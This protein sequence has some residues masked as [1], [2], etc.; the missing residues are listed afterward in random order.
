MDMICAQGTEAGG[1]TGDVATLPLI[2]QCVDACRGK[3][4]FF[5]LQVPVVA[6][7]GIFDGRGLGAALCLGATGVWVGTRFICSEEANAGPVHKQ[8]IMK[9]QSVDT[10]RTEIFTGRPCRVLK[11]E[12][13]K[14]WDGKEQDL[15]DAAAHSSLKQGVVPW[16]EDMKEDRAKFSDFLPALMG[17]AVGGVREEK[18]AEQIVQERGG[19]SVQCSETCG[20]SAPPVRQ[21]FMRPA[22]PR[23]AGRGLVVSRAVQPGEILLKERAV[24]D[25]TC[26]WQLIQQIFP[27]VGPVHAQPIWALCANWVEGGARSLEDF[28]RG[29]APGAGDMYRQHAKEMRGAMDVQLQ[30]VVSEDSFAE[31]LEIVRL[32]A[33]IVRDKGQTGLGLFFWLHLANHSCSPNA[34]FQTH[35]EQGRAFAVLRALRPMEFEEEICISYVDGAISPV[36]QPPSGATLLQPRAVRQ[37][38][39]ENRFGFR[40]RCPRCEDHS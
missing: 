36:P 8:R 3:K 30:S 40:C 23:G 34:F 14:S 37:K 33:H 39:L 2:P 35:M 7:G 13:V 15:Q 31:F 20:T 19:S 9:A 32:D 10:T 4:N 16:V 21:C 29:E 11:T 5:G 17:Q 6:A 1:H 12:Y 24:L 28:Y 26:S 18:K 38:V 25:S 22:G 27:L